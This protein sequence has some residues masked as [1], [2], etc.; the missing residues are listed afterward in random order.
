[1]VSN[2]MRHVLVVVWK[3]VIA[4]LPTAVSPVDGLTFALKD[5]FCTD[6]HPATCGSK[7]LSGILVEIDYCIAWIVMFYRISSIIHSYSCAAPS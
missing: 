3:G 6:T 4:T 2:I 1:M 7:F 5:N